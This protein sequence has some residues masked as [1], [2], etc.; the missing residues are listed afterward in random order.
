MCKN[1]NLVMKDC[2]KMIRKEER[3]I[4]VACL[5][6]DAGLNKYKTKKGY[7]HSEMFITHSEQQFDYLYWKTNLLKSFQLFKKEP[8]IYDIKTKYKDKII[9]KKRMRIKNSKYLSIIGKWIYKD[10]IK[11][12]NKVI[13]YINSPMALAIWFMDDGGIYRRK[14]HHKDGTEYYLKPALKLCTHNFSHEEQLL[15]LEH[16]EQTYRIEGSIMKDKKYEYLYFN[17]DNA[18]IIWNLIKP[19][20]MQIESM[21]NKFDLFIKFYEHIE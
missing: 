13:K 3:E 19:Y 12:C 20:V 2:D 21:R 16:F 15:I 1:K 18:L 7:K 11:T 8:V 17:K 9:N 6:G 5:L 4:I 10:N 14:K